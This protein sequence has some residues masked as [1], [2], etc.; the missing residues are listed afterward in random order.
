MRRTKFNFSTV[1]LNINY[2]LLLKHRTKYS[3]DNKRIV[4]KIVSEFHGKSPLTW[5]DVE[6]DQSVYKQGPTYNKSD[7]LLLNI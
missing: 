5:L 6:A 3:T 2:N 1:Q 7:S 4:P